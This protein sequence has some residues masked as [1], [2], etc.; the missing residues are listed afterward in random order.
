[1]V[2][3]CKDCPKEFHGVQT[4]AFLVL[5]EN[6]SNNYIETADHIS[7]TEEL[8]SLSLPISKSN[9]QY[10]DNTSLVRISRA[11]SDL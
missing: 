2:S 5:L 9:E 1:L 7:A 6:K 4:R 8:C 11:M 10:K 3:I